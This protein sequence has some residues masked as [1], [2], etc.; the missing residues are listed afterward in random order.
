MVPHN[1]QDITDK[2]KFVCHLVV[3]NVFK[4]RSTSAQAV[5]IFL[6][7]RISALKGVF[8]KLKT[9]FVL[10]VPNDKIWKE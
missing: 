5:L 9:C 8:K 2:E 6:K 4:T 3:N 10:N 1:P 7:Y